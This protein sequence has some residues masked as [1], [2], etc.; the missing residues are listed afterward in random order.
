MPTQNATILFV[1]DDVASRHMLGWILRNEGFRVIEAGSG[2]EALRL[3]AE[4]P[5]L[6]VLDVNLPDLNGFEVCRRIRAEPATAATPVLHVS[7]VYIDSGDRSEGLERGADGYL[8]KP[9]EPRE[10]LATVRALLRVHAAEAAARSA[11]HQWRC[12]FDA[13]SD[14]VCVIDA[15]GVVLRC[16]RAVCDLLGRPHE[17]VVGRPYAAVIQEAFN[18]NASPDLGFG[19][20]DPGR[21]ISEVRLG[22]RWFTVTADPMCDG[23]GAPAGGVSILTDVTR[24]KALEEQLRQAQ[25]ME[26]V[27]RLAGGVAHDFN[28]LLT[29]VSGNAALLLQALSRKSPEYELA[30]AIE[31][32]AWRAADLTRQLLGFSRQSL[33]WLRPVN[34][35]DA[36]VEAVSLLKR[37]IDPRIDAQVAQAPNL[38]LVHADAGQMNQVLMNL[39]LNAC[40][41][42][43][44]GG[45][46]RLETENC[47]VGADHARGRVEARAGS[48]VRLRVADT[49]TGIA[50]EDLPRIFDPF[51]TTKAPGKGT[52]LGLA[53]VFGIVKQH[54]GWIECSSKFGRGACFDVYLP[55]L[56]APAEAAP[57][58]ASA[59]LQAGRGE[60][61]L[62]ADDN[63]ML[64]SLGATI[65]RQHGYRVLLAVDGKEAVDMY[66]RE[67]AAVDLVILDLTMPR[68]SGREALQ[69]LLTINPQVRVLFASGYSAA[70]LTDADRRRTHGFIAKP[71]RERDLIEAVQ[72]A[73][74]A[75]RD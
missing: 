29:A 42:M 49:G 27:G 65:L 52:G 28:N 67:E 18:L 64:R 1:D 53:M 44:D 72:R 66:Q 62:L 38:A 16:N 71:Y 60:T 37:T 6:V 57:V 11:A 54:E 13:I 21:R 45:R 8:V 56:A 41:A 73:L 12:T 15:A 32:A 9:V 7:A 75:A 14:P 19:D 68:L 25:K 23:A 58:V 59:V 17:V 43:P 36:V 33:L 74:P 2:G 34:L 10:M 55:R 46:L 31:Q 3:A 30:V 40:D 47:E 22:D 70:Q 35:N 20:G 51:F 69:R 50:A 26:A 39:C 5:D 4:R 48:F 63:E 24:R 61:V